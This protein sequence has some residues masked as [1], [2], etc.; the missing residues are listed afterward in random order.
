MATKLEWDELGEAIGRAGTVLRANA[1]SSGLDS[2]VPTCPGWT[3]RDL[4]VHQ[5]GVHRWATDVLAG[6]GF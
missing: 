2:A 1:T 4:V 3:V 6:K 5:G